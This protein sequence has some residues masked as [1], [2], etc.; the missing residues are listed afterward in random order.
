MTSLCRLSSL[1]AAGLLMAQT[2]V[3]DTTYRH[4]VIFAGEAGGQQITKVHDNGSLSVQYSYRDNGRGPTL[5]EEIRLAPDGT[6]NSYRVTGT[7]TFGASV[8]E[9]FARTG[10]RVEWRS[11]SDRG[12]LVSPAS[13]MYVPVECSRQVIGLI[14]RALLKAPGGTLSALPAGALKIEKLADAT[15]TEGD[16]NQRVTLHAISGLSIA[17][18]FVW[19]TADQDQRFFAYS[20]LGRIRVIEQGWEA[21][22]AELDELQKNAEL[23]LLER[24]NQQLSHRLAEPVLIRNVRVFDSEH[25][26]LG[27]SAD[28]YISRGKIAAIYE[29]GSKAQEAG[30]V[31]EGDGGTL[32]P[33]LFDMH[34]HESSWNGLLQ[35]AGG[36]TTSRDMGNDN[37][38][39]AELIAR[40]DAGR[41][42]GPNIVPL[43]FIEGESPFSSRAGFLA[44]DLQGVKDAV[45]WYA[46]RGFRQIKI[47]N[48][49]RPEWVE[50]AAAYAHAHGLRVGGHVPAFM[51]AEEAVRA[52]Y[53]EIN[54]INQVLLNFFVGPQ[55][56]TR[57]LSRF[58]LVAD[59]AHTLDLNS[60]RVRDFI[61]LLKSRGTIIDPTVAIFEPLFTQRSGAANPAYASIASHVPVGLQR[62]WRT[63]SM[64]VSDRNAARYRASFERL[65]EFVGKLHR[66]GIPLVAGTDDIAGFTLHRE[67]ELYVQAGIPPVD[68]LRIATWNGARYTGRLDSTGAIAAGKA[69]DLI[70]VDG[71]PTA[72]I[73]DLRRVRLTMKAGVA[74]LP[75]EV[76]AALGVTRFTDPPAIHSAVQR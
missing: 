58:Y 31:I 13:S 7:S 76:Y 60:A 8:D 73:S 30:T 22:G 54:H 32:L 16:R 27:P 40:I 4:S 29:N 46:Q 18:E 75:S 49:F 62:E 24:L 53:D 68:A 52:G 48:S 61:T 50:P 37:A 3:A 39:L 21:H 59:H 63:N 38:I 33:G 23:A 35:I 43:G 74:Y 41:V 71:D 67:L 9:R 10:S 2:A 72:N 64:N 19:L 6:F 25:A 12:S 11:A 47:Y 34:N 56:D 17:P 42:V 69:A 51:R 5:R 45:D 15:L 26:T 28:V 1:A 70:L 57:T 36:V 55:D 14:A 44:K 20:R 66:E 65:V